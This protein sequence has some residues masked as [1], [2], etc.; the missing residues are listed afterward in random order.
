MPVSIL[1]VVDLPAPLG[2]QTRH[3]LTG[4]DLERDLIHRLDFVRLPIQQRSDGAQEPAAG[5]RNAKGL[6]EPVDAD[7]EPVL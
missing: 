5:P 3:H 4:L 6:L 7:H 2:P 1:I